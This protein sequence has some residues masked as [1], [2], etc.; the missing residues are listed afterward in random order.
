ME[1]EEAPEGDLLEASSL[2]PET[3]ESLLRPRR[4]LCAFIATLIA[5]L[6]ATLLRPRR[7]IASWTSRC[8]VVA[9]SLRPSYVLPPSWTSH[10][11]LIA[12]LRRPGRLIAS[13][14]SPRPHIASVRRP[15]CVRT[16][17]SLRPS[18]VL[19]VPPHPRRRFASLLRP[20]CVPTASWTSHCL[21]F[22]SLLTSSDVPSSDPESYRGRPDSLRLPPCPVSRR[23]LSS[24]RGAARR[25]LPVR[26]S[27]LSRRRRP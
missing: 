7:P 15:H 17:P 9:S 23:P 18:C 19:D 14:L 12:S 21:L 11:V 2:G 25:G 16:A 26:C 3:P 10:C 1:A 13:L 20:H 6:I 5:S 27:S 24:A 8:V 4:P 22:A